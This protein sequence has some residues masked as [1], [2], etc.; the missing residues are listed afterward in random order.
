MADQQSEANA[1]NNCVVLCLLI[2]V[3]LTIF[4]IGDLES[5]TCSAHLA[6]NEIWQVLV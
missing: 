5:C 1:R 4:L 3:D 2:T 6:D